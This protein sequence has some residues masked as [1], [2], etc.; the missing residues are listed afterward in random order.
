MTVGIWYCRALRNI[1]TSYKHISK[2]FGETGSEGVIKPLTTDNE[3]LMPRY[4]IK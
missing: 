1:G 3:V 2:E 4:N